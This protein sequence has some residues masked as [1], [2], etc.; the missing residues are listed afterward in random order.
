MRL[1]LDGL[2]DNVVNLIDDILMY[3]PTWGKHLENIGTVLS[4]LKISG[5]TA[6]PSKC[7]LA[8]TKLEFLGHMVGEGLLRVVQSKID[9]L[10]RAPSP[11]TITQVRS[12]IGFCSYYRKFVPNF[13]AIAAP[14]YDL[15]RKGQP[16]LVVWKQVHQNAF[17]ELKQAL[18]STPI[19]YLP[20]LDKV[21]VLRT[22]ASHEG[23]GAVLLQYD[24]DVAHP[25][26]YASRKLSS[27]ES[28][29]AVI[30]KECLAIIWGLRKF[31]QYLLLKEFCIETD[32][33]PLI[34]LNKTRMNNGRL[35]RWALYLQT[36]SYR[37]VAIKGSNNVGAD[38]LSR[39]AID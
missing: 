7:Y 25:I 16:K 20:N 21:F 34:Y 32:H 29:Y 30:E 31:Q 3:D 33:Q 36:Y 12:F 9:A 27:A 38:F 24:E 2:Q 6:K 26:A 11:T 15:T 8:Y 4:R 13:A 19:L 28:N 17:I 5:L 22:D 37:I 23:L 10:E 14:L 1:L 35:M 18:S 39:N